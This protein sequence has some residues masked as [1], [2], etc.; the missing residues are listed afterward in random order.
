MPGQPRAAPGVARPRIRHRF[1]EHHAR[2]Q[3]GVPRLCLPGHRPAA[4][5]PGTTFVG[6]STSIEDPQ[7]SRP[8]QLGAAPLH[9]DHVPARDPQHDDRHDRRNGRRGQERQATTRTIRPGAGTA[10]AVSDD[11]AD[12]DTSVH[13]AGT[14]H[15]ERGQVP[16]T[17]PRRDQPPVQRCQE[18]WQRAATPAAVMGVWPSSEGSRL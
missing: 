17:S 14:V 11:A 4:H 7:R 2:G 5:P 3:R 6:H 16:R 12:G 13:I 10:G 15:G 9:V 8:P 1:G 18:P